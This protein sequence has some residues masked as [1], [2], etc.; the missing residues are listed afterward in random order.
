MHSQVHVCRVSLPATTTTEAASVLLRWSL[1][2]DWHRC[3][4]ELQCVRLQ[5]Q[6]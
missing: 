3:A 2:Q 6:L 1:E 4:A 5:R